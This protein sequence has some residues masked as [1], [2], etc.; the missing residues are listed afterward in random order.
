MGLENPWPDFP[1][2]LVSPETRDI[3]YTLSILFNKNKI[4]RSENDA[5]STQ[6]RKI[7]LKWVGVRPALA[8][9][10][11]KWSIRLRPI[12]SFKGLSFIII[13]FHLEVSFSPISISSSPQI[14]R[15]KNLIHYTSPWRTTLPE[16][17]WERP[18]FTS[19]QIRSSVFP[20]NFLHLTS[21]LKLWIGS[22]FY[23]LFAHAPL[24]ILKF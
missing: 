7:K 21:C 3:K 14:L 2:I 15:N 11:M 16:R 20:G 23:L 22:L 17:T 18:S 6:P 24:I 8:F 4:L 12:G 13:L 1:E 5:S 9:G 10:P 19:C